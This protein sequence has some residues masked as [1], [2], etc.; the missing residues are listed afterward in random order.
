MAGL[1][2][3]EPL[4]E[5]I[6]EVLQNSDQT[7]AVEKINEFLDKQ[8]NIPLN[9]AVTGESGSGKSTFVN[10]FRGINNG[11]DGAAPTGCV[12]TTTEVTAYPHPNYPNVV[13]WDLPG[14]GTTKFPANKYKK[15]VGLEKYDFFIII[16][17]TRFR[18]NDVRLAKKIRKMKKKFY[19][20][21]SKIDRDLQSEEITCKS[22]F[23]R[24]KTLTKIRDNC[25]QGLQ[26]EG[27]ES[28]QV[29]LGSSF[30][31]HDFDFPQLQETLETELPEHKKDALLRTTPIT[32]LEIIK[33][34]KNAFKSKIKYYAAASAVGAA[35]PV[36]GL[37]IAVD[38]GILIA[39]ITQYV[40][41]F[42][43]DVST[44]QRLAARINVPFKDLSVTVSPLAAKRVTRDLVVRVLSSLAGTAALMA[45]EEGSRLI[46]IL[47]IPVSMGVSFITTYKGL[48]H[49]L[50]M[51][52][53]DSERVFKRALTPQSDASY[54]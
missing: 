46:P 31:L 11:D 49:I 29:F 12:E 36:P 54:S 35:V 43:L 41:G 33:K 10:A 7:L 2:S 22:N 53:E 48:N 9:I 3:S 45:T 52:T 25:I 32:S 24:E 51:L 42:G 14:I 50:D 23:D 47:G 4:A 27:F 44:L 21:R 26:K 8:N 28:P 30:N 6:K 34:K 17:D 37:S 19:F 5:V 38:V 39:A 1:P 16:S 13:L 40:V 18:E 20:V 15:H